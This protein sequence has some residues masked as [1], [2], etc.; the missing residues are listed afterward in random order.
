MS[1]GQR[2]VIRR[3]H[4]RRRRFFAALA[5]FVAV[6]A[7]AASYL[8]GEHRGG[9][10]RFE[11]ARQ[12]SRLNGAV[13]KESARN[14]ELERRTAFLEHSLSL[15][16]SSTAALKASLSTQQQ[17]LAK[18]KQ[19]LAFYEG[20]VTP[21]DTSGAP[22]RIAGLQLIPMGASHEYRFQIVLVR[23]NGRKKP[24]LRGV[25]NVTVSGVRRGK[26][27]RL[28]LRAASQSGDD[29]L[30]FTLG[31]FTNLAGILALPSGFVP[32]QVD[33]NVELDG[34]STVSGSYSWLIF[35]G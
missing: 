24:L 8:V 34:G 30:H 15:A 27:E 33:V 35:R 4:P 17:R 1:D 23:T 13:R 14:A 28:S 29:K 16:A 25:C 21:K 2:I 31:Y 11:S 10:L 22:V 20:L 18:L 9:F 12:I 7:L 5:L 26:T 3:E 19:N 32:K 6:L